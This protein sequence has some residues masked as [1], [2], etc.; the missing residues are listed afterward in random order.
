[1]VQEPHVPPICVWRALEP[2]GLSLAPHAASKQPTK[3][4]AIAMPNQLNR[5]A[6]PLLSPTEYPTTPDPL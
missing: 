6:A 3:P 2:L 4:H 5:I 1:M